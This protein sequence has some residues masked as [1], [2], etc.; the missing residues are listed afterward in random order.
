MVC[1]FRILPPPTST[2]SPLYRPNHGSA[3]DEIIELT[4]QNVESV[5]DRGESLDALEGKADRLEESSEEFKRQTVKIRRRMCVNNVK[6]CFALILAIIFLIAVLIGVGV[7]LWKKSEVVTNPSAGN[8]AGAVIPGV[9]SILPNTNLP[10]LGG[11][12]PNSDRLNLGDVVP[13]VNLPNLGDIVEN[14]NLPNIGD[15][16]ENA[17]LPILGDIVPD[18]RVP[19]LDDVLPDVGPIIP[20]PT[21]LIPAF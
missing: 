19:N 16:V 20:N 7:F 11:I 2:P 3:P 13:N 12:L 5:M 10:G 21:E 1:V 17:N 8:I 6:A 4:A 18:I 15:I 14:A 9:D